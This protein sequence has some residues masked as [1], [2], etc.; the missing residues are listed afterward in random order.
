MNNPSSEELS[1]NFKFAKILARNLIKK[2]KFKK[3]PIVLNEVFKFIDQKIKVDGVDLGTE[4]GFSIGSSVIKYNSTKPVVRQRFTVAHEL[5]HILMGHNTG[6][7]FVSFETKDPNEQCANIFASELL[8]PSILLKKEYLSSESLSSLA[9]KYN[10]SKDMMMWRLKSLRL[11][12][13]MG[14]WE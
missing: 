2:G 9:T 7:R 5:G 10:V 14:S 1:P 8:C 6:S 12:E 11:D 13:K 4:D 3:T